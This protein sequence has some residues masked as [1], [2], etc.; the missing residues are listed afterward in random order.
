MPE[1]ALAKRELARQVGEQELDALELDDAATRLPTLVDVR[2]AVLEGGPRDAERVR[3]D[4]GPR[5][6]E[7][8]EQDAEA[9]TRLAKQVG[10][11]RL[12]GVLTPTEPLFWVEEERSG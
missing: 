2:D 5:L 12:G 6:V 1:E 11:L 4:R 10:V 3:G 9:V 8:G 7:R